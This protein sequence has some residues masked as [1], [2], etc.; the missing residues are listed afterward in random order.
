MLTCVLMAPM[1]VP[2][3]IDVAF[4]VHSIAFV[5]LVGGKTGVH[6]VKLFPNSVESGSL[7]ERLLGET[8][9]ERLRHLAIN[10][11]I[12]G[13][14]LHVLACL[15]HQYELLEIPGLNTFVDSYLD[16]LYTPFSIIL[17][18]EVYELIRAIPESFSV[19]IGK[20]FE[21]MSLVVVRDM[22]KNLADVDATSA[23]SVDQDVA[24]IAL[25]ALAFVVLFFTALYFRR[26][27]KTTNHDEEASENV[28]RF[29]Q[30]KKTL[31]CVLVVVYA[32]LALY[33]FTTWSTSTMN[34]EGDLSRTVF[35]LD[36]FTFLILSD[37]M[38]LLVSYKHIVDFTQLARNTGFVLST[39]TIRVG[40]GTP[41]FTGAALFILAAV[42]A[43]CVL[44]LSLIELPEVSP[45]D[46]DTSTLGVSSS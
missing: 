44:R 10:T 41:G 27:T 11:A 14:I 6:I 7:Y 30:Q 12:V 20:Q 39:V 46:V 19:S 35:F 25:E 40:I 37:I 43:G 4:Q 34:G 33:S 2:K 24:L 22:F 32:L 45:V 9:D 18:Y 36:F 31:A 5:W 23:V 16:A 15:L 3:P 42:L 21:V 26:V 13:F 8:T 17:A 38:I 1:M 28:N 29:I